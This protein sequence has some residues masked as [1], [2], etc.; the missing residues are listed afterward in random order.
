MNHSESKELINLLLASTKIKEIVEFLT[1]FSMLSDITYY[2]DINK[3]LQIKKN[4]NDDIEITDNTNTNV[5]TIKENK[6]NRKNS[7][8]V[9]FSKEECFDVTYNNKA[10]FL[11]IKNYINSDTYKVKFKENHI[12]YSLHFKKDKESFALAKFNATK[13]MDIEKEM[14]E[15]TV[16][17]DIEPVILK[18][19]HE[20]SAMK[21][22][23]E[24]SLAENPAKIFVEIEN[25][26][27]S[28]NLFFGE[29]FNSVE[30]LDQ[31]FVVY[32]T[33]SRM[34]RAKD[35]ENKKSKLFLK[36]ETYVNYIKNQNDDNLS[37]AIAKC[38]V[39]NQPIDKECKELYNVVND[40]DFSFFEKFLLSNKNSIF[41]T[42]FERKGFF[43]SLT[44][45]KSVL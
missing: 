33:F 40:I 45:E 16:R 23:I 12:K 39:Y 6:F 37:Q 19:E 27:D 8:Y 38:I 44:H 9:G 30:L 32:N 31:S 22:M 7:V 10:Y 18:K 34:M 20:V 29:H 5:S 11:S 26:H 3:K 24:Y 36:L 14:F 42:F 25:E 21:N 13:E 1:E 28:L 15:L 43:E 4:N 2:S 17:M 41:K 35:K